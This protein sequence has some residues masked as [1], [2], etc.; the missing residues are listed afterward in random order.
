MTGV[1]KKGQDGPV[2][3]QS[4]L[5]WILSGTYCCIEDNDLN[6]LTT[7]VN[8]NVTH[9]LRVD[10][11]TIEK[12]SLMHTLNRFWVIDSSGINNDIEVASKFERDL[13][14]NGK[15]YVTKSPIKPH[16]EFLP[17]NYNMSC[18]SL[19]SLKVK[20]ESLHCLM[21]MTI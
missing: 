18:K 19:M 2:A 14:F 10:T 20:V 8:L 9:A 11:E 4:V 21:I 13:K 15:R 17:D 7:R 6:R 12:E 3:I 1:I 5:G 16:H